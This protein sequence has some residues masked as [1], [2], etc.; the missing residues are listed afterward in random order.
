MFSQND[1]HYW[2]HQYG[3]KGLLLNGAVIASSDDETNIFYNPGA[4]GLDDNL[5]FAFS[6]LSPTYASLMANNYLGD[7][8]SVKDDG[9]DLSPGF[10]AIRFQP[11]KTDK[12]TLAVAS[13][14]RFKSG[15]N[16]RNRTTGTINQTG[17]FLLRADLNFERRISEDWF[18][19]GLSVNITDRLGIGISQFSTWRDESIDLFLKK[20]V[21]ASPT[22]QDI[23]ASWRNEFSYGLSTYSGF[24]SKIGISYLGKNFKLGATYTSPT[25]GILGSGISYA[26][27]D[28]RINIS[29]SEVSVVSNR[30]DA[31]L[32]NYKSPPSYGIGFEILSGSLCYSLSAEYFQAIKAY[33]LFSERDDSF[34]GMSAGNAE[35]FVEL[36]TGNE[37]VLNF[38]FGLQYQATEKTTWVGGFRTDFNESLSLMINNTAEYLSSTP[39]VFHISGGAM[40]RTGKNTFSMGMDF[41]YGK[42]EGGRQLASFDDVNIDN[43]YSFSGKENVTNQY[44]SVMLFLTYDFIFKNIS[45]PDDSK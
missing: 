18:G 39:N 8:S 27:D 11:F 34:D 22:P 42:S 19:M 12:V 44:F 35:T 32:L 14:E 3:A 45:K 26:L 7:K 21:L 15:I 43:L 13:F 33:T 6:F 2:T 25:Y 41:G 29:E 1:A 37:S 40:V 20:E 30:D 31:E 36:V 38:A 5:G 23:T 10:L 9:F 4:L 28:Q 17:F 16:F 24:V